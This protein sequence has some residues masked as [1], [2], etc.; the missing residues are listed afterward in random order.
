MYLSKHSIVYSLLLVS[1]TIS[2]SGFKKIDEL[3]KRGIQ[4]KVFP[5]GVALICHR[6]TT[7][8]HKAFGHYTYEAHSPKITTHTLF[9]VASLTKLMTATSAMI[10]SDADRLSLNDP[11]CRYLPDFAAEGKNKI[12]IH[13]LLTHT[14]GLDDKAILTSKP[15]D[16]LTAFICASK[17]CSKAGTKFLY[18]DSDM[19][20]LQAVIEKIGEKPFDVFVQKNILDPLALRATTFNP[21]HAKKCAPTRVNAPGR[22]ALVQGTVDDDRAFIAGGVAGH[23]G[24]F[25]TA[26]DFAQYMLMILHDGMHEEKQLIQ[27]QTVRQWTASQCDFTHQDEKGHR[28]YGFEIGRHLSSQA[29]GHF[30]WSGTSVWADKDLDLVCVL[31]TNSIHPSYDGREKMKAFRVEFHD[32]VVNIVAPPKKILT[33]AEQGELYLPLL[34]NKRV[35]ILT[36]HTACIGKTHLVDKLRAEKIKIS[37][38]FTPEH[39]FR[40]TADA[41]IVINNSVDKKTGIP[42]VSLYGTKKKPTKEDLQNVDIL[43]FDIQ[44]VGARFYTYISSLQYLMEAA[45]E[46]NIPLIILDRPNPNGFYVDGP[47]CEVKSFV[48]M[49]PIPIVHGM[50]VGEYAQM[51]NGERWLTNKL[52]CKLT[53]IPC[54]NYTHKE[55]Y[56]L[57]IFPSPNLKTMNAIYLYPSLCL[58]EGTKMSV[59]HGT[60]RPFERFGHPTFPHT[61]ASFVPH[62]STNKPNSN[63]LKYADTACYGYNLVDSEKNTLKKLNNKLNI[64]WLQKAYRLYEDKEHFFTKFFPCLAGN[65]QL[66][67]QIRTGVS[68]KDIRASWQPALNNFKKIRKIYLLYKD[69]E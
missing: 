61:L 41:E 40:G 39:G 9:D 22:T 21:P 51:L 55:L 60:D 68:E 27:P 35:G 63:H 4:E 54:K 14:S 32:A 19:L 29:F 2:G 28:G 23:A 45:A 50:T 3:M 31:F 52:S 17:P 13:H 59:G 34:Q 25:S 42:L 66:A 30:G 7:V 47:I 58:F 67:E 44:D 57:P 46:Q 26:Q 49:Q 5:G 10:L 1:C 16:N 11:V 24:L 48:G 64:T 62:T 56:S 38:I 65:K 15:G 69:F 37:T 36:N 12:C 8:F 43:L 18:N 20:I 53:I 6:G 33:G